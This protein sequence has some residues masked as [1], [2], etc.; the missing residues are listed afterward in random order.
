MWLYRKQEAKS[1]HRRTRER[2]A[3]NKTTVMDPS[4]N[5]IL[6]WVVLVI[7]IWDK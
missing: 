1:F 5:W 7:Q 4:F 3:Q 2:E 6:N